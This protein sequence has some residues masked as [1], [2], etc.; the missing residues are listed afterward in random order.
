MLHEKPSIY[1]TLA[2]AILGPCFVVPDSSECGFLLIPLHLVIP[3][4]AVVKKS[5][6]S[7]SIKVTANT[8]DSP[9]RVDFKEEYP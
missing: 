8:K 2:R 7:W 9:P 3:K 4:F 1:T 6:Y 5:H